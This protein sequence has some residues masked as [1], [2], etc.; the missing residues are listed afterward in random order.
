MDNPYQTK[1]IACQHCNEVQTISAPAV[2][3]LAWESGQ[4]YIQDALPMLTSSE[5]EMLI[6]QTCDDCWIEFFGEP[7]DDFQENWVNS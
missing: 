1:T 2:N 3:F 6:S 5:R 4:A 7:E